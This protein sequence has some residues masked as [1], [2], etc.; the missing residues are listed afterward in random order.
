[1]TYSRFTLLLF[2]AIS[3]KANATT[4]VNTQTL[5]EL[6]VYQ[7]HQFPAHVI[8]LNDITLSSEIAGIIQSQPLLVGTAVKKHDTLV[9]IDCTDKQLA[10]EQAEAALKR[11]KVQKQ[12]ARQQLLRTQKLVQAKSI[13]KQELDQ[14]QTALDE[15][16][17]SLEQQ[18]VAL[19][20][21]QHNISKCIIKAPFNGIVTHNH[22]LPHEYVT[23]GT[24]LLSFI[25][26]NA[27][28]IK[29]TLPPELGNN[30]K[31]AD[32]IFFQQGKHTFPVKIRA[33]LPQADKQSKQHV[34]RLSLAS[35]HT[36]LAN[37]LGVVQWVGKQRFIPKRYIV[38]R[39]NQLGVFI[40][41]G[42]YARF[43]PLNAA[44][45]GQDSPVNL[46]P[47]TLII[48]NKLLILKDMDNIK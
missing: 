25:E 24:P 19:K 10:K 48:T 6:T 45:E 15:S 42:K 41:E 1:M 29:T 11:L 18:Q 16:I 21:I 39:N 14:R 22:T 26:A 46:S 4:D 43:K 7:Q 23:P 2:V 47:N 12:L 34:L 5:D 38:Q 9:S 13:S 35:E 40:A 27:V 17:A 20:I 28:E 36:P 3:I 32:H 8:A 30:I 44:I 31:Q 37:S 33:A